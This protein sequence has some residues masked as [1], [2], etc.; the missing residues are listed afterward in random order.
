MKAL[1]TF[2][3][4]VQFP[5]AEGGVFVG[6]YPSTSG[7]VTANRTIHWNADVVSLAE[8]SPV[9]IVDANGNQVLED[10]GVSAE[11]TVRSLLQ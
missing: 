4:A 3:F 6:H 5:N 7:H 2:V 1:V 9:L 10:F 8:P 11:A